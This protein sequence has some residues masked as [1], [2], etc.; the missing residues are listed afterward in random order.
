MNYFLPILNLIINRFITTYQYL[1]KFIK[2]NKILFL[3]RLK[4]ILLII[5]NL[6]Y[7]DF[8]LNN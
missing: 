8:S 1:N 7:L 5:K 6:F 2:P 4:F 3:S